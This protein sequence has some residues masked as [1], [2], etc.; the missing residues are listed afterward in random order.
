MGGFVA[1]L[2]EAKDAGE[3]IELVPTSLWSYSAGPTIG[4]EAYQKI[5][6]DILDRIQAAQDAAPLDG[7]CFYLHGAGI[8]EGCDDVEGDLCSAV[9]K[10]VGPNCKMICGLDHHANVTDFH[11]DQMDLITVVKNYPHI[12]MYDVAY[13]GAKLLPGMI[14]GTI[15]PYGHYEH[16]PLLHSVVST[17]DGCL[18]APIK[19]KVEEFAKRD[20]IYEFSYIYGFP[21]ADV[22]FN[23]ATVNCWATSPELAADTAR[24]FA[25]L[26]WENRQRWVYKPLPAAD[27][28][29]Q[30]LTEL[31]QQGR[32]FPNNLSNLE[33]SKGALIN[34]EF[35]ARL[36]QPTDAMEHVMGF[37]PDKDSPG[38]IVVAD[39]SD[40][41]GSVR[42]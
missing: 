9:R 23:T 39:K 37:T 32:V 35:H 27:A 31:V 24:E 25:A 18:H 21:F 10:I 15:K 33:A 2:K 38:P 4:G 16:L 41:T 11:K 29:E 28:V 40:N 19:K 8:A 3:D 13:A 5:K 14:K 1:A 20:G 7:V 30:A 36:F 34:D 26:V 22:P 42:C 12:D 17:F 6:K